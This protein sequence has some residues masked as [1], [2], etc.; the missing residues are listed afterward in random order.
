[1]HL[2]FHNM[3][4]VHT[5]YT[6]CSYFGLHPV[7]SSLSCEQ[8]FSLEKWTG[9]SHIH[10]SSHTFMFWVWKTCE[11]R[12]R[13]V[14]LKLCTLLSLKAEPNKKTSLNSKCVWIRPDACNFSLQLWMNIMY[15]ARWGKSKN[16]S[17]SKRGNSYINPGRS[18]LVSLALQQI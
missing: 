16:S 11:Y 6:C 5:L 2:R 13:F 15:L 9:R 14:T 10:F 17:L 12:N 7:A 3:T 18:F 4:V 1:M 8:V